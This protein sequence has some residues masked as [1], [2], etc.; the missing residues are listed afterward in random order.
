[1]WWS[2]S[3]RVQ[4][5][6]AC[7]WG[8]EQAK[9][10]AQRK[11]TVLIGCSYQRHSVALYLQ[12]NTPGF[13]LY[14]QH[15]LKSLVSTEVGFS[16]FFCLYFFWIWVLLKGHTL[17]TNL[18][19]GQV[20][21]ERKCPVKVSNQQPKIM[22]KKSWLSCCLIPSHIYSQVIPNDCVRL[23]F[24][25]VASWEQSGLIWDGDSPFTTVQSLA[26]FR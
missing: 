20:F 6:P 9:S 18:R 11:A 22:S 2:L 14:I 16:Y 23:A 3:K 13:H 17:P 25:L 15:S 4:R 10:A 7:S 26:Y 19:S 1:M 5:D 8:E 12:A 21:Q 24:C